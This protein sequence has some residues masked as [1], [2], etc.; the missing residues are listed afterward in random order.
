MQIRC[1]ARIVP[2]SSVASFCGS[3]PSARSS[4]GSSSA[5]CGPSAAIYNKSPG[6]N[7]ISRAI[8]ATR[9][10]V[11]YANSFRRP[12]ASRYRLTQSATASRTP[13]CTWLW[14]IITFSF[15]N[16]C[17]SDRTGRL[18]SATRPRR[19]VDAKN[20]TPSAAQAK[21]QNG[22]CKGLRYVHSR[23]HC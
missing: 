5:A 18:T 21:V 20:L 10:G 16:C 11:Q 19:N 22:S 23:W 13:R 12:L 6:L 9:S 7:P 3:T 4:L 14:S 8:A 2:G 15:M 1:R 17:G